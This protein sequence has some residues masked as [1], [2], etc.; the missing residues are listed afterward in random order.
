MRTTTEA[1]REET[2]RKRARYFALQNYR[3][4]KRRGDDRPMKEVAPGVWLY[5]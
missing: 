4:K 1:K 3:R 2:A 5:C